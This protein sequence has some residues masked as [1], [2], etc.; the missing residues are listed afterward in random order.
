MLSADFLIRRGYCC[1]LGCKNC[2]YNGED[3]NIFVLD[4]HCEKA[5]EYMFDR[6]VIKMILESS[7]ML[8]NAYT[9]EQ[10]ENAPKTQKGTVRKY[11][12]YNHPCSVWV[13]QSGTN[14]RWLLSHAQHLVKEAVYRGFNLHSC[15]EFLDWCYSNEPEN[16]ESLYGLTEFALAMPDQYKSNDPIESYRQYYINEK[17]YDNRGRWMMKYTNREYPDWFPQWLMEKC[18]ENR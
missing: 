1:N 12:Y 16:I 2:P 3:M 14:F 9:H 7:Q 5:A 11:S 4:K 15:H 10:L 6:H 13:R 17:Q 18:D 8:A